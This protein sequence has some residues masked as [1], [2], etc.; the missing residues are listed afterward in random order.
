[1]ILQNIIPTPVYG[2][3]RIMPIQTNLFINGKV[4]SVSLLRAG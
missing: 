3:C 1:M 4:C 2:S